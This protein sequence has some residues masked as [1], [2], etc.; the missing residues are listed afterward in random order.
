MYVRHDL[1]EAGNG[2]LRSGR[3]DWHLISKIPNTLVHEQLLSTSYF[4][5]VVEIVPAL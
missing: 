2:A 4:D 3:Y 5:I 1:N